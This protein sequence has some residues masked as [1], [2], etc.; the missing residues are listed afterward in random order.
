MQRRTLIKSAAA[1]AAA[2]SL[3]RAQ[4]AW[5]NRPVKLIVPFGAG[6]ATDIIARL[7]SQ[8]LAE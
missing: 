7:V 2:P 5:P 4:G 3:A 8:R 1:L 6:G